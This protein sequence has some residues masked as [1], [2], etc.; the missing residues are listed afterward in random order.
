MPQDK[1]TAVRIKQEN[2]EYGPQIPVAAKAENVEYNEEYS[3]K[4]VLGDININ[5]GPLQEQIE[6]IDT[7]T[8]QAALEARLDEWEEQAQIP[9]T[10]V[11]IDSYLTNQGQAADAKQAGKVVTINNEADGNATKLHLNTSNDIVN[12]ALMD[13]ISMLNPPNTNGTYNLQVTVN[14]GRATYSWNKIS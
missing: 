8:I 7:S 14:N 12:I 11:A 13:D 5:K 9:V 1:L 2:G 6:N 3:V 4:E 10:S